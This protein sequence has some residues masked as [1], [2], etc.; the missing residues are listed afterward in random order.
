MGIL[1]RI[2]LYSMTAIFVSSAGPKCFAQAVP[3]SDLTNVC[4]SKIDHY[5]LHSGE[6]FYIK[7]RFRYAKEDNW[8]QVRN[9][10]IKPPK[11]QI[12]TEADKLNGTEWKEGITIAPSV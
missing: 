12:G 1:R 11:T 10:Q 7:S 5:F 8:H 9:F 4:K 2:L 6:S 3:I